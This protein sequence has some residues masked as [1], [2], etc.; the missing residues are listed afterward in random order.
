MRNRNAFAVTGSLRGATARKVKIGP[1]RKRVRLA[2]RALDVE[3]GAAERVRLRLPRPLRRLLRRNGRLALRLTATV[4]D[5]AG[6]SRTVAKRVT[7]RLRKK[8]R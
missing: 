1:R 3:A 2:R 6:N 8:R 4:E 5:P 7:P